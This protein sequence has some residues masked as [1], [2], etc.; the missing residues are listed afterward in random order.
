[1]RVESRKSILAT[2]ESRLQY[3]SHV[4]RN[5]NLSIHI[6]QGRVNERGKKWGWDIKTL[7][8]IKKWME[9]SLMEYTNMAR[10]R[11]RQGETLHVSMVFN[12][13]Y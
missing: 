11:K 13:L 9:I 10:G 2:A 6:L 3:F 7:D 1:M 8:D 5:H 4:I 12:L